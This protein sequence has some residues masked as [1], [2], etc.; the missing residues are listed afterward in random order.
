M[1]VLAEKL[2]NIFWE[3]RLGIT[4]RGLAGRDTADEEHI[5]YG[6]VPYWFINS[7]LDHLHLTESDIIVDLGCGKGRVLC[8]AAV[9]NVERVIGVE[10]SEPLAQ[11]AEK[12]AGSMRSPHCP[13]SVLSSDAQEFDFS[14]G[15][16][17]YL[18]H[19]FG[20]ETLTGVVNQLLSGLQKNLRTVRIVYVNPVHD[21]VLR[22]C[23]WLVETE[24]WNSGETRSPEHTVTWW[25]STVRL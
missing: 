11:I 8:C 14:I 17:Y 9:R 1:P 2:G 5:H 20:P 18:F 24:R 13:I 10:Y 15:T 3:Y 19:P 21:H 22:D 7:I 23:P 4:T 16:V 6:T 25:Q 12:N